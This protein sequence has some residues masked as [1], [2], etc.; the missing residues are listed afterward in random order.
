VRAAEEAAARARAAARH[1][2]AKQAAAAAA[3]QAA[4]AGAPGFP[5]PPPKAR[6][7]SAGDL[8]ALGEPRLTLKVKLGGGEAA[9]ARP[10]GRMASRPPTPGAD[11][12]TSRA[13][14]KRKAPQ[15]P[16]A[17]DELILLPRSTSAKRLA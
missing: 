10:A 17:E 14:R 5:P 13:G 9:A 3:Q 11:L 6:V 16:G 12:G 2:A 15:L 4:A 1:A 7:E 8:A